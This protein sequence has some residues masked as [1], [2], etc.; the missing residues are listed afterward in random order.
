M[1]Q[2]PSKE[3]A[4]KSYDY[5]TLGLGY[6]NLGS[7][8]MVMGFAYDS[9]EGRA[10]A[11]ALTAILTGEAYAQSARMAEAWGPFARYE[12]NREHMLRVIRN[13]RRAAY[14]APGLGVRRPDRHRPPAWTPRPAPPT[15]SR[16]RAT[17]GTRPSRSARGAAT[18]TPR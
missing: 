18:A 10:V 16:P 17:P 1:A 7:L 9:P 15:S 5:R 3:I 14:G 13:H 12:A 4:R 8:L 2:F 11:A 6:A